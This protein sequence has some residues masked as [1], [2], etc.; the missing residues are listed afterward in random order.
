MKTKKNILFKK[1]L[2]PKK[3]IKENQLK[4]NSYNSTSTSINSNK[5]KFTNIN[6]NE[7][8]TETKKSDLSNNKNKK[9]IRFL[10][11]SSSNEI[12]NKNKN[13]NKSKNKNSNIISNKDSNIN[14]KKKYQLISNSNSKTYPNPYSK[15]LTKIK[16]YKKYYRL[17]KLYRQKKRIKFQNKKNFLIK[18]FDLKN[19]KKFNETNFIE[20]KLF[21]KYIDIISLKIESLSNDLKK[22]K[23]LK[24]QNDSFNQNIFLL[25]ILANDKSLKSEFK[26]KINLNLNIDEKLSY[27]NSRKNSDIELI[28]SNSMYKILQKKLSEIKME[29]KKVFTENHLKNAKKKLIEI[30]KN[31]IEFSKL[32]KKIFDKRQNVK[33]FAKK[34]NLDNLFKLTTKN[35]K[36]T[37]NNPKSFIGVNPNNENGTFVYRVSH[38]LKGFRNRRRIT[39]IRRRRINGKKY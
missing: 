28:K 31:C 39:K 11:L 13:S 29:F 26:S 21:K 9:E 17:Y 14:S 35:K 27:F 1:N 15:K 38:K 4:H 3:P 25:R 7:I 22:L 19:L 23:I 12:S 36:N 6:T 33:K 30:I 16:L 34:A 24:E 10:Q 20:K 5:N 18:N 37:K 32:I 2:N 8:N